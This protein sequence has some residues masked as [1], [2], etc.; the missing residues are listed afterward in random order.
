MTEISDTGIQVPLILIV[1]DIPKNLQL[2]SSILSAE[3]YQIAFA[4]N[5]LQALSVL[6]TTKPDLI[7]LDIMMPELDGYEVCKR[8]KEN[9]D[10]K[11]I[12]V[13]FLTGRVETEDVIR[14]F[15]VGAVD[16]VTKPF[17]SVELLIRVKTHIELKLSKDELILK[18]QQL[19]DYQTELKQLISTKDKFFSIIA[20]DL[21]GP[22]SGF[23]GL[24]DILMNEYDSLD[25]SE[26]VQISESMNKAAKRLFSFLENLLEWSSTQ[27]GRLEIHKSNLDIS[28]V[29]DKVISL[30][31]TSA[32]DKDI[33]LS[34]KINQNT[35][36]IADGNVVQTILRNLISN[37]IKFTKNNGSVNVTAKEYDENQVLISVIDNGV[38]MSE[39]VIEKIFK[40][41]LK[42]STPG[43]NNESGTGL[44][45]VLC[46]E[47][48]NKSDGE[49][50]VKSEVGVGT[51]FSFTLPKLN[52]Q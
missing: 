30:L 31:S 43:T 12:P 22:F 44:G 51:T 38:G 16:Y 4:S 21:R 42:H 6:E 35:Y 10:T 50:F 17:N 18:N 26:I 41:D 20:H 3:G 48:V 23:L 9:N 15:K 8:L 47:L 27:T 37:A 11:D 14:G 25:K 49:L 40:L 24:S 46:K 5:G 1:D 33:V 39:D 29:A 7:L 13:I 34:N 32:N 52:I 2:L 36:I 45:I 19:H 28:Y